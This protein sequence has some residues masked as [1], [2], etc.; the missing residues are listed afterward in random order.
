MVVRKNDA[1]DYL[2][3]VLGDVDENTCQFEHEREV[4]SVKRPKIEGLVYA[5]PRPA[6]LAEP[7]IHGYDIPPDPPEDVTHLLAAGWA[8]ASGG[9]VS[10]PFELNDFIRG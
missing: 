2:E 8:W 4:I 9:V 3:G 1:L 6:E 10:T 5:H 7:A